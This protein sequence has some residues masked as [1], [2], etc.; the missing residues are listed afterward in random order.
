MGES[1]VTLFQPDFNRSIEVEARPQRLSSDT[2][3]LLLRELME[4]MGWTQLIRRNLTDPR[5]PR[6]VTH[7]WVELVRTTVLLQALGWSDQDDVKW[8]G[9]DPV[10]ALAVSGRRGQR[11]VRPA[12]GREP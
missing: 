6:R 12:Q 4:R 2:G 10:L 1:Q 7:P 8:L 5:D 11:P 9:D 3:A